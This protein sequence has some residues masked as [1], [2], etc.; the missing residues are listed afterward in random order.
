MFISYRPTQ[1]VS[2]IMQWFKGISSRIMLSEYPHLRRQMWGRHFC[3]RGYLA[4]SSGNITD[5]L[6]QEYIEAQEGEPVHDD[7]R[8]RIDS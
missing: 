1:T 4:V 7:S 8:F 3:A 2:K 5:E 6:I